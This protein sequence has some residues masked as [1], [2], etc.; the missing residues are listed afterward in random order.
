MV[1]AS[2]SG[3]NN[4]HESIAQ[5]DEQLRRSQWWGDSFA[6][7]SYDDRLWAEAIRNSRI[8]AKWGPTGATRDI[9]FMR[10][11]GMGVWDWKDETV[12]RNN[13]EIRSFH[14]AGAIGAW[15]MLHAME[16]E[17]KVILSVSSFCGED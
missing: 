15:L 12:S 4:P 2:N 9:P 13:S 8:W 7:L 6:D 10:L 3:V 11:L 14:H 1:R 16:E 17:E 5:G